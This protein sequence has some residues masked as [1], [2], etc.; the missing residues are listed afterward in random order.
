MSPREFIDR[1]SGSEA[2]ESSNSQQFLIDLCDLLG[3]SRL[4][5]AGADSRRNEYVFERWVD[6]H[7]DQDK[8]W[9][10]IDLYKKDCFV[11]EAKQ[12]SNRPEKTEAEELGFHEPQRSVGIGRR[13]TRTW[14]RAMT[15]KAKNQAF[16]YARALPDDHGWPPF[17]IVVDIGPCIDLYADF[18]RQLMRPDL[19]EQSS[20]NRHWH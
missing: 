19:N 9:G 13:G 10:E 16:R 5:P 7:P 3:V 20:L 11:L 8:N 15:T 17:L 1:W 14:E 4:D 12:G 18:A 2:S 6:H